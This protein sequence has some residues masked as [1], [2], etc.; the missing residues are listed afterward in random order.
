MEQVI[1]GRTAWEKQ[2]YRKDQGHRA[3]IAAAHRAFADFL[4]ADDR[5]PLPPGAD[6]AV[7]VL[8]SPEAVDEWAARHHA[9][10]SWRHGT[11]RASVSFGAEFSYCVVH[12]PADVLDERLDSA[13]DAAA[14]EMAEAAA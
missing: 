3:A 12:I 1:P 13:E 9:A 6:F 14:R 2:Q 4:E 5:S 11:Y 7:G 10:A 8:P